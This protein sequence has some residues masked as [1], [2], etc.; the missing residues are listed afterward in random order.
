MLCGQLPEDGVKEAKFVA[1]LILLVRAEPP[2]IVDV[3]H[4]GTAR[5]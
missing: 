1:D 3:N 5:G 2:A 4:R